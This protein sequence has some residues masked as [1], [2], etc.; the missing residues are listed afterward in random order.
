MQR[1]QLLVPLKALFKWQAKVD[2]GI[3]NPHLN[4][5][6]LNQL[7]DFVLRLAIRSRGV[8]T[9][10]DFE[11]DTLGFHGALLILY[12]QVLNISIQTKQVVSVF[13]ILPLIQKLFAKFVIIKYQT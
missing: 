5:Q 7:H 3:S 9:H 13:L 12:R 10:F 11:H 6:L 8:V 2:R 1:N 4:N